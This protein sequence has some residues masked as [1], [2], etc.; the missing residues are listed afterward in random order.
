MNR[1]QRTAQ[2]VTRWAILAL[3]LAA[4]GLIGSLEVAA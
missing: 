2:A 4:M 1:T 3:F